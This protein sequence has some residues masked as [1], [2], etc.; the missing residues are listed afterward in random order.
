[1]SPI[2]RFIFFPI[3]FEQRQPQALFSALFCLLML[4]PLPAKAQHLSFLPWDEK[5]AERKLSLVAGKEESQLVDLHPL[6]RSPLIRL[7]KADAASN[8]PKLFIK[9]HDRQ[10]AEG[11]ELTLPLS[12]PAN[13]GSRALVVIF[14]KNSSTSGL[15]LKIFDD[16][17][18]NFPWGTF[19]LLNGTSEELLLRCANQQKRLPPG[20]KPVAFRLPN[21]AAA[22]ITIVR[23]KQPDRPLYT[24]VWRHEDDSRRL[25]IMLPSEDLRTGYLAFKAIPEFNLPLA[26]EGA[27]TTPD[28][29]N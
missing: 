15:D 21:N 18:R 7:P 1:M 22:G 11:N 10:D 13:L 27:P 20:L 29:S 16:S 26:E 8:V 12:L 23:Q 2:R 28:Q 17:L 25:I 24:S 5:I 4:T 14:P 9:V 3:K 6:K 19:K